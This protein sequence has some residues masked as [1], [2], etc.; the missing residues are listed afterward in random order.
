MKKILFLGIIILGL[1][2]RCQR[3]ILRG[4]IHKVIG[5]N[6]SKISLEESYDVFAGF[7]EGYT[8]E[9]YK[10]S[11]DEVQKFIRKQQKLLP[12]NAKWKQLNWT[13]TPIDTSYSEI[14]VMVLNF[15]SSKN[16]SRELE[17]MSMILKQPGNYY[18][19]YYWPDINDPRKVQFFLLDVHE[20]RI[21][22]IDA[23]Y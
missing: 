3:A 11:K 8:F 16:L 18:S 6:S 1:L 17:K 14:E 23:R 10:L 4:D 12:N 7:G 9:K 21:Y 22:A 19:F 20:N 5:I 2:F 13:L 15:T